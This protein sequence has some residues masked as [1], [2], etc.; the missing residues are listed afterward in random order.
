MR[1]ALLKTLK[2]AITKSRFWPLFKYRPKYGHKENFQKKIVFCW[3]GDLKLHISVSYTA[4][5]S[6][7][8]KRNLLHT[9]LPIPHK[10]PFPIQSNFRPKIFHL[11]DFLIKFFLSRWENSFNPSINIDFPTYSSNRKRYTLDHLELKIQK[12][13][14]FAWLFRSKIRSQREN[15]LYGKIQN[16]RP[17]SPTPRP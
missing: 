16:I 3:W 5:N 7:N 4:G 15:L 6:R 14:F 13:G 2:F 17:T 1:Y 10:R 9:L 11:I 8:R 12:G